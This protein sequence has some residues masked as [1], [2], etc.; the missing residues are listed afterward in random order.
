MFNRH[1]ID[2]NETIRHN[3]NPEEGN[4]TRSRLKTR[5]TL[6]NGSLYLWRSIGRKGRGTASNNDEGHKNSTKV[7]DTE[8][9]LQRVEENQEIMRSTENIYEDPSE[10]HIYEDTMDEILLASPQ[11]SPTHKEEFSEA[12]M[13]LKT[14]DDASRE[15]TEGRKPKAESD[16]HVQH[17]LQFSIKNKFKNKK[18]TGSKD[19]G[20]ETKGAT[21]ADVTPKKKA[22]KEKKKS[23]DAVMTAK[24]SEVF[25]NPGAVIG[26]ESK[27]KSPSQPVTVV[28][29]NHQ[30]TTDETSEVNSDTK[31]SKTSSGDGAQEQ[32]ALTMDVKNLISTI[33][34]RTS[35]IE[36]SPA[37]TSAP[38]GTNENNQKAEKPDNGT[39][40]AIEQGQAKNL[41]SGKPKT[42][43]KKPGKKD[44]KKEK[45]KKKK[46]DKKSKIGMAKD[47]TRGKSKPDQGS[48]R[49]TH[50]RLDTIVDHDGYVAT[51]S[52]AKKLESSIDDD[53]Y[54]AT[55]LP[56]TKDGSL[57][58][59]VD[60]SIMTKSNLAYAPKKFDGSKSQA[61]A[62]HSKLP[63]STDSSDDEDY[64]Y[65]YVRDLPIKTFMRVK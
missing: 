21:K 61:N 23:K 29:E 24:D 30:N 27:S 36:L 5:L 54:V 39:T 62:A 26:P 4:H 10:K 17:K 25:P 63:S 31:A 18:Q 48:E 50:I 16:H 45:E 6:I 19:S 51:K 57:T 64:P 40:A 59:Y 53:G 47:D 58:R 3:P 38:S 12:K 43:K 9:G 37:A 34:K 49:E 42:E 13:K 8:G 22:K 32:P 56:D 52:F 41:E 28:V 46:E 65:D 35:A 7:Q 55:R 11:P 60:G 44:T 15:K 2:P 33:E 14:K 1:F 20:Q